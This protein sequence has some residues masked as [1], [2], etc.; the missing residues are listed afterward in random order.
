VKKNVGDADR[1]IR[2]AGGLFLLGYGITRDSSLWMAMGALF[3][4]EGITRYC[5]MLDAAGVS[6]FEPA[7]KAMR[8]VRR[9]V[10]RVTQEIN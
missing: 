2:I 10:R 5:P 8:Q 9:A 3:V 1:F 6:T 7:P 4:A